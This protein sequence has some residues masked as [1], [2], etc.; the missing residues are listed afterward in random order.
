MV[1]R[2]V[3]KFKHPEVVADHYLYMGAVDNHNTLMHDGRT[4]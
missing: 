4:K 1:N 2:E 3:V